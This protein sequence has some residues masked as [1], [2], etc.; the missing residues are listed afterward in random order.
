ML[1]GRD[2]MD[3]RIYDYR[4]QLG[5]VLQENFLFDG[6]VADNIRF[7]KPDATDEDVQHVARRARRGTGAV[8][9]P[10]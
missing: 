5:V 10:R 9:R 6:T 4:R 7:T 2:L 8:R 1:D 3:V